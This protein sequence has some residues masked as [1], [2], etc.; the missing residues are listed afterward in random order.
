MRSYNF[1]SLKTNKKKTKY[2]KC[3]GIFS[4]RHIS[5]SL[6]R[7]I[8]ETRRDE[9]RWEALKEF[10]A[11]GW[12]K[13]RQASAAAATAQG[14]KKSKWNRKRYENSW[15]TEFSLSLRLELLI[16]QQTKKKQQEQ[17]IDFY[18]RIIY[19]YNIY[20]GRGACGSYSTGQ[21]RVKLEDQEKYSGLKKKKKFFCPTAGRSFFLSFP[22][23]AILSPLLSAS[24]ER[25]CSAVTE[26]SISNSTT[27]NLSPLRDQ[28]TKHF[29]CSTVIYSINDTNTTNY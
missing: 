24:A 1:F 28:R 18:I 14:K 22:L 12:T 29:Y 11:R 3:K 15:A 16:K 10:A 20:K 5:I 26:V 9:A 4:K 7:H 23:S 17:Q 19:T 21:M 27:E 6:R 13:I 2:K 25:Q 8:A